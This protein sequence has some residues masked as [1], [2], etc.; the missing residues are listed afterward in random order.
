MPAFDIPGI[1]V[2][3]DLLADE[4]ADDHGDRDCLSDTRR[5]AAAV[6]I[7]RRLGRQGEQRSEGSEGRRTVVAGLP[8]VERLP[9]RLPRCNGGAV[10]R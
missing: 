6:V 1:V 4:E 10:T 9:A 8:M 3:R 2:A 7:G 5:H